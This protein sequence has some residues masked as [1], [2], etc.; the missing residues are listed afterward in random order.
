MHL[1]LLQKYKLEAITELEELWET[2]EGEG[3]GER[4]GGERLGGERSKGKY[5]VQR[6]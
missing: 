3:D 6:R 4:L 5:S 2:G 1:V